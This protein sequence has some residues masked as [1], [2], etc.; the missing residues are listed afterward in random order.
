MCY[1]HGGRAKDEDLVIDGK[2][3]KVLFVNTVKGWV[4]A[5]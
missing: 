1:K 2:P 3:G 4:K 5:V